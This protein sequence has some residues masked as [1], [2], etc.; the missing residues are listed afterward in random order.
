MRRMKGRESFLQLGHIGTAEQDRIERTQK[1]LAAY[2]NPTSTGINNSTLA[3]T[4]Y[5][6]IFMSTMVVL[7][8]NSS[9]G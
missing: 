4:A 3:F 2:D 5:A 1:E 8:G 7:A 9:I 6:V